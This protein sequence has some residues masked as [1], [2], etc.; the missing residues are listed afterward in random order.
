MPPRCSVCSLPVLV[1]LQVV[2]LHRRQQPLRLIA[3]AVSEAGYPVHRDAIH[4][5]LREHIDLQPEPDP[6]DLPARIAALVDGAAS[7]LGSWPSLA[8]KIAQRWLND[9]AEQ[10]AKRLV[11]QA[12]PVVMLQ[13]LQQEAG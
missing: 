11:S 13:R 2:E 1:R 12:V 9:G 10:E 8:F 5:H 3:A 6:G 4:R 7:E